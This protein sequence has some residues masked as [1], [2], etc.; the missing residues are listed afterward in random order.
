M[1]APTFGLVD[2]FPW[3]RTGPGLALDG[4]PK[5]DLN[6]FN[7]SYFDRLRS[8]VI[9]AGER[10]IYVSIMLFEGYGLRFSHRDSASTPSFQH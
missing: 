8:R 7:Q 1:T 10:G 3:Q 4:K 9:A 2:P 5:F 6:L